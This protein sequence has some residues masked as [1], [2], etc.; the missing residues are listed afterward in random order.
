[1]TK[2]EQDLRTVFRDETADVPPEHMHDPVTAVVRRAA[3][4]RRRRW[5]LAAGAAAL[6]VVMGT[7]AVVASV[8][9]PEPIQVADERAKALEPAGP[10]NGLGMDI[11]IGN[12]VWT[13]EGT[14][15]E[16]P[17]TKWLYGAWWVG[18]V[19]D[20]W[21]LTTGQTE[22][23]EG[24]VSL[25]GHDGR[26]RLIVP[27]ADQVVIS[28]DGSRLAWSTMGGGTVSVGRIA[29]GSVVDVRSFQMKKS[30]AVWSWVGDW[31]V[32]SDYA[33][34]EKPRDAGYAVL[35][36]DTGRFDDV[37][38]RGTVASVIGASPDG[39]S[40]VARVYRAGA[41]NR[42]CLASLDPERHLAVIT[43]NCDVGL[44]PWEAPGAGESLSPDGR[45][46]L[47]TRERTWAVIDVRAA[48]AGKRAVTG[49]SA[50]E[51]F[52]E[53]VW[54]GDRTVVM[55]TSDHNTAR[56]LHR[57]SLGGKPVKLPISIDFFADD[58]HLVEPHNR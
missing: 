23:W 6:A 16:V 7:G 21:I 13:A 38:T 34:A 58:V 12:V 26:F 3:G 1:M 43:Q 55:L 19:R 31:I 37:F 56:S 40:I 22:D 10:P 49:H 5:M 20:G 47:D 11:K 39:R 44:R 2:L 36:P 25:M 45:W 4:L 30:A 24:G 57:F 42:H 48:L 15:W 51:G 53:A 28:P 35:D 8:D 54:V 29:G 18:R 14:R 32:V 41:E 17:A 27:G 9:R 50:P 46:L 52:D 33:S